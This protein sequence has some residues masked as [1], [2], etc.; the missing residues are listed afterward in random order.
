MHSSGQEVTASVE[1]GLT[2]KG[3]AMLEDPGLILL[4]ILGL[5]A[6]LIGK[7]VIGLRDPEKPRKWW[8]YRRID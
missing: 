2:P 1:V 6:Y 8:D 7:F 3:E 4:A 5:A